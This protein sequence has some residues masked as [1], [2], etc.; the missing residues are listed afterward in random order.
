MDIEAGGV[1]T[2]PSVDAILTAS[3]RCVREPRFVTTPQR[4]QEESTEGGSRDYHVRCGCIH[5]VHE[6]IPRV[7]GRTHCDTTSSNS[8]LSHNQ[9]ISPVNSTAELTPTPVSR[10]ADKRGRT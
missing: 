6:G 4:K 2:A 7:E 1:S 8:N 5:Q 9:P 3:M 10:I